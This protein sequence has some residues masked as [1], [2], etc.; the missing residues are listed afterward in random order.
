MITHQN[1][2]SDLSIINV[3]LWN[4]DM[5]E[6]PRKEATDINRNKWIQYRPNGCKLV[7]EHTASQ[8][9]TMM[10]KVHYL[11]WSPQR[12]Y[13][14]PAQSLQE[15]AITAVKKNSSIWL[16]YW[17][18]P[19]SPERTICICQVDSCIR[20]VDSLNVSLWVKFIHHLKNFK[21]R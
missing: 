7:Y 9:S 21:N 16:K 20:Q 18:L 11:W 17:V 6:M 5:C 3:L 10:T 14:I 2:P 19:L 4:I 1:N 8:L 15:N 12:S 13:P